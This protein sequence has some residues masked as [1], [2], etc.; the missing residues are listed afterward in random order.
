MFGAADVEIESQPKTGASFE[1]VQ[2][3]ARGIAIEP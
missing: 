3:T 2:E 1:S